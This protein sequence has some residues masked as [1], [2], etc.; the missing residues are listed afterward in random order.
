M[1]FSGLSVEGDNNDYEEEIYFAIPAGKEAAAGRDLVACIAAGFE[2]SL[3]NDLDEGSEGCTFFKQSSA[4]ILTMIG[5]HGWSGEWK[6][7]D[8][9]G[10]LSA[11]DQLA[12]FNRGGHWGTRGSLSRVR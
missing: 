5:G 8:E 9:A 2:V 6:P 10:V 7:T 4:G 1:A 11:V 3:R 12:D